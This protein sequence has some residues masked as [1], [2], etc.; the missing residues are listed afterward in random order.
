MIFDL[1]WQELLVDGLACF[2]LSVMLSSDSGPWKVF[3]L[4]RAGLKR[5]AK[6]NAVVRK[7][8]VA[9]GA[10]CLRC[11]SVWFAAPIAAWSLFGHG[12]Y[13]LRFCVELFLLAMALSA[14]AIL[15][16]RMFPKR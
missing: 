14:A 10:E 9:H 5:E 16:Q 4:L 8:D 15:F 13:W 7:S 11:N 6:H 1:S 12:P 3:T 2:R